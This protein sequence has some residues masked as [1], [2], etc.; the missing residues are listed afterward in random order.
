MK[1]ISQWIKNATRQIFDPDQ[2]ERINYLS[3]LLY[4]SM[5]K[6]GEQFSLIRFRE[7]CDYTDRDIEIAKRRVY[8]TLL[9]R[10]WQDDKVTESEHKTLNWVISKLH[11]PRDEAKELQLLTARDRF[12]VALARA[13]DD[14]VLDVAEAKYLEQISRSVGISLGDFVR[15]YFQSE[16]EHFLRGIFTACTEGGVLAADAWARLGTATKYLG[17]SKNDLLSAVRLQASRFVEHV[18]ADAKSDGE[19]SEREEAVLIQLVRTF[20]LDSQSTAYVEKC[21]AA[22]RI[23][24]DARRG[25][26]PI[27]NPPSGVTVRS[28][29]L[30]HYDGPATWLQKRILKSGERWDQHAGS[31]T[32]TDNRMLFSSGTKSFDVRF[33][34]IIG[35]SGSTGGIRLQRLGKPETLIRV[36][37]DE[38]VA[39]AI[40][41]GAVALSTQTRLATSGGLPS[42]HIPREIRQ[43]V[44]QRYGGQCAECGA[45]QY[46]E[47]DHVIPVAKGGSNSDAN[48]QL[49]CRGC[50]LKKSDFI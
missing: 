34:K 2:E 3:A 47:F 16:G 22:L 39:Y 17:L 13:M 5:Q 15:T 19:L 14:G 27:M 43:R 46:L 25:R 7:Q 18:L 31:L 38:P 23:I 45:T 29:E 48:V 10:A 42:R 8:Q 21:I 30:V 6:A 44:W 12:A 20:Q 24:R 26:L 28:G 37:E 35:H 32:I 49:L 36:N 9:S 41:E 4:R 50:N 1:A 33:G 11:I 40:F